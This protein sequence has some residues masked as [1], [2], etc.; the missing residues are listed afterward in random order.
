MQDCAL[1]DFL[2]ERHYY[3]LPNGE[4]VQVELYT[5][6]LW[7]RQLQRISTKHVCMCIEYV[8]NVSRSCDMHEEDDDDSVNSCVAELSHARLEQYCC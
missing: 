1:R 3:M 2:P 5:D 6:V 4:I 8:N 7:C